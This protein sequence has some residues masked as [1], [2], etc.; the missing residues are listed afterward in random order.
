[1]ADSQNGRDVKRKIP[2]LYLSGAD[3]GGRDF[4]V[5]KMEEILIK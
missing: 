3:E 4:R 5:W 2:A 1:M